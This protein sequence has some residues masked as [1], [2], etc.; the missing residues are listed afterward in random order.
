VSG[1]KGYGYVVSAKEL[2]RRREAKAREASCAAHLSALA[3]LAAQLER[4]GADASVAQPVRKDSMSVEAWEK[5]LSDAV[6]QARET[7]RLESAKVIQA[8]LAAADGSRDDQDSHGQVDAAANASR[9]PADHAAARLT[10]E[11]EKVARFAAAIRDPS[12]RDRLAD[13]AVKIAETT[14]PK[15]AQAD[16]LTLKTRVAKALRAQ[17]CQD[18]AEQAV[19]V[20]A[21]IDTPEAARIRAQAAAAGSVQEVA[22]VREAAGM[23]ARSLREQEEAAYVIEALT[24]ALADLGFTLDGGFESVAP[25]QAAAVA[26]HADHPGYGLRVEV[27]AEEAKVLTRVVAERETTP[28]QDARAEEET[29]AKVAA[30]ADQLRSRGVD[31]ALAFEHAPGAVAVP[32]AARAAPNSAARR[33]RRQAQA[34]RQVNRRAT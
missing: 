25:N 3:R 7:L 10:A 28:E 2:D 13:L 17:D 1:P 5:D 30:L 18:L 8:R 12:A 23:L 16:L 34:R 20:I 32:K 9:P 6:G 31:M 14:S 33:R 15:Q 29:C 24:G 11:L 21:H 19:R 22:A 4:Y 27:D 26:D